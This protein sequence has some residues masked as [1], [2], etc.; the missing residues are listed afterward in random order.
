MLLVYCFLNMI[1]TLKKKLLY[2]NNWVRFHEDEVEFSDG[3]EGKYAYMERADSG[4]M[5]IP[6]T[7]DGKF[8]VLKE[9]R[10]PIQDWTY[11]FPF[12]GKFEHEDIVTSAKREL[13]EETGFTASEWIELGVLQIDPGANSQTTPIFLAQGLIKGETKKEVSEIHEV[14]V[15]SIEKIQQMIETQQITNGWFLAGFSKLKVYLEKTLSL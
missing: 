8:V 15:F 7:A 6:M 11:C 2:E 5:I 14:C 9:W 12:G 4:P 13:E 1:K 10:Y 3:S